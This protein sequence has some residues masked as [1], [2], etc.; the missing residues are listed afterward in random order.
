[1]EKRNYVLI[2]SSP[3]NYGERNFSLGRKSRPVRAFDI[4]SLYRYCN[5][6]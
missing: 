3:R 4:V 2:I 5:F 6:V 1:M